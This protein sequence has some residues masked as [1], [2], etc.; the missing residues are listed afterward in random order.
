MELISQAEWARKNGFSKQY[1][2]QLVKN[3]TIKLYNKKINPKQAD[4]AI[5]AIRNPAHEERRVSSS[6]G[7]Y[8]GD[9]NDLSTLLLKTRIKN[10]V[11][12]GKLLETKVKAEAGEWLNAEEVKAAYFNKARV[13]RD[14]ILNVPDRVSSIISSISDEQQIHTILT[15][16]LRQALEEISRDT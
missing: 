7:S 16:E 8:G 5:A 4:A 12:K 11:E 9:G 15:N 6:A 3:G 2:G 13:V 10:E 14:R 1:A